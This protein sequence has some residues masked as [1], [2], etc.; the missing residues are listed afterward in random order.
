MKYLRRFRRSVHSF[1]V[2]RP[3]LPSVSL[4]NGDL[5]IWTDIQGRLGK[6]GKAKTGLGL[7]GKREEKTIKYVR[8]EAK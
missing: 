6:G 8:E 5:W 3:F 2:R 7:G 1:P 4:E